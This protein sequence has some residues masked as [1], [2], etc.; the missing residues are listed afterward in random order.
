MF[1]GDEVLQ[2]VVAIVICAHFQRELYVASL[3]DEASTHYILPRTVMESMSTYLDSVIGKLCYVL[4]WLQTDES[5]HSI[6]T[7]NQA[8]RDMHVS[9]KHYYCYHACRLDATPDASVSESS[10]TPTLPDCRGLCEPWFG[11][12]NWPQNNDHWQRIDIPMAVDCDIRDRNWVPMSVPP[13]EH[14]ERCAELGKRQSIPRSHT[15]SPLQRFLALP[16]RDP[17]IDTPPTSCRRPPV[18]STPMDP[19][20]VSALPGA[21][22]DYTYDADCSRSSSS[23]S[24]SYSRKRRRHSDEASP[25]EPSSAV[26]ASPRRAKRMRR[27]SSWP[28]AVP[29]AG[30]AIQ[31]RP[32]ASSPLS[33]SYTTCVSSSSPEDMDV[34][35]DWDIFD[36]PRRSVIMSGDETS[37][38]TSGVLD[39]CEGSER[40]AHMPTKDLETPSLSWSDVAPDKEVDA[41]SPRPSRWLRKLWRLF[42]WRG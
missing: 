5:K 8:L 14:L 19:G 25:G 11:I 12:E 15:T 27:R 40:D 13:E 26:Q 37:I 17:L 16:S 34:D 33:T 22:T 9:L 18:A 31:R 28:C 20:H 10:G 38:T 7:V 2:N 30:R 4:M 29:D 36:E 39:E 35:R 6:R 24:T 32:A 42:D 23:S 1:L 21:L 3:E 41:Y